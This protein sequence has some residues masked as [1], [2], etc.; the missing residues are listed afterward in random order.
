MACCIIL[1]IPKGVLNMTLDYYSPPIKA[2]QEF[3]SGFAKCAEGLGFNVR[4][5]NVADA[6]QLTFMRSCV[7]CDVVFVDATV[8]PNRDTPSVYPCLVPDVNFLDH[9]FVFSDNRF[10]LN[11]VPHNGW[12]RYDVN[13]RP[14][15][16]T[17][18]DVF[19]EYLKRIKE[20]IS[21]GRHYLR[22]TVAGNEDLVVLMKALADV[23]EKAMEY[24][25]KKDSSAPQK[26]DDKT[27]IFISYR[28]KKSNGDE[29]YEDV[30]NFALRK[31]V[32]GCEVDY[33]QSEELSAQSELMS[34]MRKWFLLNQL[35]NRIMCADEFWIYQSDNYLASWWTIGELI[36][37][38]YLNQGFA[39]QNRQIKIMIYN[40]VTNT[41]ISAPE[42]YYIHD[43]NFFKRLARYLSYTNPKSMGP[44]SRKVLGLQKLVYEAAKENPSILEE[45]KSVMRDQFDAMRTIDG[46]K[47]IPSSMATE[48]I[49]EISSAE[50]ML[51]RLEDEVNQDVFWDGLTMQLTEVTK[52]L[53]SFGT[54]EM[55]PQEV[56]KLI[57][58]D[59]FL[60][61]PMMEIVNIDATE[62][63]ASLP[64]NGLEVELTNTLAAGSDTPFIKK[65]LI[66]APDR[67]MWL[68]T[69]G[70]MPIE[71]TFS[72][73]LDR[74]NSF[75]VEDVGKTAPTHA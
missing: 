74:V 56:N 15:T 20:E 46:E 10:P 6:N 53:R 12:S 67:Y 9:V 1:L 24:A 51:D 61:L 66:K 42:D 5:I 34:P 68:A 71:G 26:A 7:E 52:A 22:I 13:D 21:K 70:M 19:E 2:S 16:K 58:Y 44:E 39:R 48:I 38:S 14:N 64:P 49:D 45:I 32:E 65:R 31:K 69:R 43:D 54:G 11:I 4:R 18:K 47:V 73:G 30:K 37:V 29:N 55:P 17:P 41:E 63:E 75:R 27:H 28:A 57:D 33:V 8:P 62:V 35:A 40:P 23:R 36:L 59:M 72:L 50:K 3:Y 60:K 25:A